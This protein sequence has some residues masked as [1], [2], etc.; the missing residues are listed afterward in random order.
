M[1]IIKC[2]FKV[3]RDLCIAVSA[4]I[5]AEPDLYELD[6]EAKAVIKP[7]TLEDIKEKMRESDG[8]VVVETTE[9]G[10]DRIVES[11]KVCPVLA[12]LVDKEDNGEWKRVYPL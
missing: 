4:C 9:K 10:F 7:L 11:A 2:R 6:D 3:D 1:E 8:W 5:V 12:I